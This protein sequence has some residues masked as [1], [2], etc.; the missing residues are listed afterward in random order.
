MIVATASTATAA[1]EGT[2]LGKL[3]LPTGELRIVFHIARGA[4]STLKA[5]VDSPDQGATGIPVDEVTWVN[6]HLHLGLKVIG[7]AFEGDQKPGTDSIEGK[8]TQG[9][10]SLPLVVVPTDSVP[11]LARPQEPKPPFPYSAEDV[12]YTNSKDS[13]TL[14]ATL[15]LPGG[16]AKVPAVLLITGSGSQDRDETVFGHKPFLILSD[17]LTRLGIAVLR[18]DDRGFGKSTAGR[19]ASNSESF[20]RDVLAGVAYLKTRKEIDSRR[21][22]LIGHSEGGIIAPMVAAQSKDVAFIVM[23][24]GPGVTGE[25]ILYKQAELISRASGAGDSAVAAERKQQEAMFGILETESDSLRARAKLRDILMAAMADSA[26]AAG[27]DSSA[28]ARA[29]DMQI[30]QVT[31][32]WF[33]YFLTYDPRPALKKVKCPVLAINGEK[34]LQV[35]PDLNI[36]AIESALKAGGN[37]HLTFEILPGLNHLFQTATTGSPE[38]YAKIEETM[39]PVALK[40]IGDW[41]LDVTDRKNK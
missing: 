26:R 20:A 7:G 31:S 35:P 39:S 10:L 41:I 29:I 37:K 12:S 25:E 2:W 27:I 34:D 16:E 24:A 17:Y 15:T 11:P 28:I 22:G 40:T 5:T 13:V 4:D 6:S 36:P 19:G 18:A 23:M 32:P 8:W 1:I 3:K 33:R 9:G 38:E 30:Q 14:A 21:I